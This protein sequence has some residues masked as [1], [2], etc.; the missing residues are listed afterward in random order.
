M[1]WRTKLQALAFGGLTGSMI[2]FHLVSSSRDTLDATVSQAQ[3]IQ[4]Q[5][6]DVVHQRKPQLPTPQSPTDLH[7]F[8]VKQTMTTTHTWNKMVLAGHH[9]LVSKVRELSSKFSF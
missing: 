3:F 2:L 9:K 8:E 1:A 7:N 6:A 5:W 4:R